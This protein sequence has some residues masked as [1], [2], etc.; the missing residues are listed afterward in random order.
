MTYSEIYRAM[1]DEQAITINGRTGWVYSVANSPD[2]LI[3]EMS[4]V[5]NDWSVVVPYAPMP[6]PY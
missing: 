6:K 1:L 5:G 4:D 2:G 3:V